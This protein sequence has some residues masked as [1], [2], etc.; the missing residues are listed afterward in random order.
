MVEKSQTISSSNERLEF[1]GDAVLSAF[2][3]ELLY[4]RLPHYDEGQLTK[5]R[6]GFVSR[7]NLNEIGESLGLLEL[8]QFRGDANRFKSLLGNVVEALVGAI[9]LDQG[10]KKGRK[11]IREHFIIPYINSEKLEDL[12]TDFKS[13][14]YIWAQK[15]QKN[16]EFRVM[17][18]SVKKGKNYFVIG[19]FIND[20]L[21]AQEDDY[22]KKNAEKKLSEKA[23]A[24]FG[25]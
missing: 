9:Y 10:H 4:E 13:R 22:T 14:L 24:S 6:S 11:I 8:I 21:F 1:L 15:E 19:L 25:F 2:V 20:N 23:A 12:T 7:E 16:V 5:I 3:S 17:E 18:E